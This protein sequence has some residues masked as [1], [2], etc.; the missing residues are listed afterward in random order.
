MLA[1]LVAGVSL[2]LTVSEYFHL[3]LWISRNIIIYI[4]KTS[5][6]QANTKAIKHIGPSE[7]MSKANWCGFSM[8][9]AYEFPGLHSAVSNN[10]AHTIQMMRE[11]LGRN[12]HKPG[13]ERQEEV[14]G[15]ICFDAA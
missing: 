15:S 4:L 12:T 11:G 2:L 10:F 3:K 6:T 8:D 9:T 14:W 7:L 5:Y 13:G 1:T